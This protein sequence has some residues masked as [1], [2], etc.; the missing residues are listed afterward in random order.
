MVWKKFEKGALQADEKLEKLYRLMV[1]SRA[2]AIFVFR[3]IKNM[4]PGIQRHANDRRVAKRTRH[5]TSKG[6][7]AHVQGRA[8]ALKKCFP[9]LK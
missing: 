2:A 8:A 1:T 7:A 6:T 3:Q 4:P 5:C 9:I